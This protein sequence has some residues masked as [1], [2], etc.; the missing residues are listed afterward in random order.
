MSQIVGKCRI[1]FAKYSPV[2]QTYF[3]IVKVY[4]RLIKQFS[5]SKNDFATDRFARFV[6]FKHPNNE[7]KGLS[8]NRLTDNAACCFPMFVIFKEPNNETEGLILN[9]LTDNGACSFPGRCSSCPSE[10]A[11]NPKT[12]KPS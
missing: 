11:C 9:S 6:I 12:R 5:E 4:L 2:P 8:L 1:D 7:P 3:A 10:Q